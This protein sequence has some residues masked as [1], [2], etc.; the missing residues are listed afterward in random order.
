MYPGY[1]SSEGVEAALL[2]RDINQYSVDPGLFAP[3]T[4]IIARGVL[5]VKQLAGIICV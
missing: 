2:Q 5:D 3:S 1:L 4:V